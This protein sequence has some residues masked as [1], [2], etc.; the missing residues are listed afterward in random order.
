MPSALAAR[1][2]LSCCA[3]GRLAMQA[4]A[5]SLVTSDVHMYS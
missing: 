2:Q 1:V 4:A 5:A 3:L